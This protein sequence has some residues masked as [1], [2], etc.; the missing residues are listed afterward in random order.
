V[1]Y[2]LASRDVVSRT[3]RQMVIRNESM[4]NITNK[5]NAKMTVR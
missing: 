5:I 3:P 4:Q 1:A 2:P